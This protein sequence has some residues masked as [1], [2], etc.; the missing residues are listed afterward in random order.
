MRVA[1]AGGA[2]QGLEITYLAGKAG[3]ETLLLDRR[4]E[5]PASRLC[6]HFATVDLTDHAAL[7]EALCAAPESIDMVI[8]ATENVASTTLD[9]TLSLTVTPTAVSPNDF[10]TLNVNVTDDQAPSTSRILKKSINTT[11]MIKSVDTVVIGGIVKESESEDETG[12]PVLRELPGVGWL[13]KARTNTQTKSEL[14]IFLTP[15]V[16]PPPA[17]RL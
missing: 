11:L 5:A 2:L 15:T 12:V 9:A 4:P 13:F 3:Y 6:H 8:P 16:I 7:N 17:K 1:I 14:L 10:I